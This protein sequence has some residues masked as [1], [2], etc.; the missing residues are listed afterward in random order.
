MIEQLHSG[1][2]SEKKKKT[3]KQKDTY[4]SMSTESLLTLG[5]M[6]KLARGPS[7]DK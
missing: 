3:Q 1:I 2:N 4:T 6:L 5:K 7:A